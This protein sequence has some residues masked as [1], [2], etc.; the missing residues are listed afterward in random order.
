MFSACKLFWKTQENKRKD[1]GSLCSPNSPLPPCST[2]Y[3][4]KARNNLRLLEPGTKEHLATAS[5]ASVAMKAH[6]HLPNKGHIK[7][8][9]QKPKALPLGHYN[10]I[11]FCLQNSWRTLLWCAIDRLLCAGERENKWQPRKWTKPQISLSWRS[12]ATPF[13]TWILLTIR[14]KSES[15]LKVKRGNN[16]EKQ[17]IHTILCIRSSGCL[18]LWRLTSQCLSKHWIANVSFF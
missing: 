3:A 12:P 9:R 15:L 17:N 4:F 16:C 14:K 1:L 2:P 10:G 6:L 8:R 13:P 11:S 18:H 5:S 7:A